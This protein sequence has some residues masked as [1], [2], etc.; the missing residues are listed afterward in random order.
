MKPVTRLLVE[1]LQK[2]LLS[3]NR[4]FALFQRPPA[5]G[6]LRLHHFLR[7]LDRDLA[8]A[9]A[10]NADGEVRVT[11]RPRDEDDRLVLRIELPGLRAVRTCVV[12]RDELGLLRAHP[13]L[14]ALLAGTP[15]ER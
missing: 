10:G 7:S 11:L 3:R 14:R 1:R 6:A 13:E 5:Q 15:Q 4:H 9:R 2:G 8:L 12:S